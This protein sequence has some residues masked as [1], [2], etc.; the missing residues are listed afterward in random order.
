VEGRNEEDVEGRAEE[1]V[2]GRTGE[3]VEEIRQ[4]LFFEANQSWRKSVKLRKLPVFKSIGV[5]DMT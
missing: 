1:G 5:L 4:N 3:G 2:G